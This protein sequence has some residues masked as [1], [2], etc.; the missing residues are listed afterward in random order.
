MNDAQVSIC[1]ETRE[2]FFKSYTTICQLIWKETI[3][4]QVRTAGIYAEIGSGYI[5]NEVRCLT[6]KQVVQWGQY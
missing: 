6:V 3:K 4:S 1:K 2:N 5:S